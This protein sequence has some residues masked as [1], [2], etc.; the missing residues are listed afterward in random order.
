N[1]M[2]YLDA[3]WKMENIPQDKKVIFFGY[4]QGVSVS[5]RWMASRKIEPDMLIIH[6]GGIPKELTVADFEF[7]KNT[8]V[9]LIYGIHDEYLTEKRILEETQ[10]AELLFGTKL[11]IIPFEGKHEINREFIN[12]I[13]KT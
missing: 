8:K 7:L 10:R 5:M 11:K 4:S 2:S 12:R 13:S 3:V 9:F 1:V 6:S